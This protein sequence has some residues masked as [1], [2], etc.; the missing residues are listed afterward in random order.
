M[1]RVFSRIDPTQLMIGI[2]NCAL[3]TGVPVP[4]AYYIHCSIQFLMSLPAFFVRKQRKLNRRSGRYQIRTTNTNAAQWLTP[5]IVVFEQGKGGLRNLQTAAGWRVQFPLPNKTAQFAVSYGY[6]SAMS[7]GLF[8]I[9]AV[10]SA[11]ALRAMRRKG[12]VYDD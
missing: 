2:H 4:S 8:L 10:L 7:M 9:I 3:K 1:D 6:A 12:D 5:G 11:F